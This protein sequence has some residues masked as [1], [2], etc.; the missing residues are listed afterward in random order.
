[1]RPYRVPIAFQADVNRQIREL[2]DMGLIRPSVGPVASPIVRVTEK[3][4]GMRVA[5]DYQN[6]NIFAV[7]DAHSTS[8]VQETLSEIALRLFVS[9]WIT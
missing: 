9:P 6:W 1:M 5:S 4:D 7:G 8:K 2:L 3:S